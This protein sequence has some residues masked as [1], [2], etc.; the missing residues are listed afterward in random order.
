MEKLKNVPWFNILFGLS[1]VRVIVDQK[2]DIA[3]SL[4][5]ITLVALY[6]LKLF[7]EYKKPKDINLETQKQLE[8]M[9]SIISQIGVKNGVR[10]KPDGMRFF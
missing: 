3:H 2:F 5:F 9:K 1:I 4:V 8:E 10:P 7:F 6:G